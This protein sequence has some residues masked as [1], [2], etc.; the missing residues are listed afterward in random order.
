VETWVAR[1]LPLYMDFGY[2]GFD[3]SLFFLGS[4]GVKIYNADRMQGIDPTY[5]FNMYAE[6]VNRW[7]G[8]NTSNS[9]PRM[10]TKRDNRNYRT[11]DMF[12][13]DGS[14]LRLKNVVIGYTL[15]EDLT[16]KIG[17]GR[18]RFYITGQNVFT[19][20]NYSGLDP[21]LGYTD[22]NKQINVDYAQY[23]QS[24]TWIFGANITF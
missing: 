9:I 2:K 21:E 14:F 17:I 13:E 16:N 5:S 23:P 15:K 22:G 24:R 7:N 18:T 12:I 8:P 4:A 6:T 20:T 10:T 19:F 11:S 1:I 3:L